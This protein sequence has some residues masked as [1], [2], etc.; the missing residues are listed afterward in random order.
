MKKQLWLS[1]GMWIVIVLCALLLT[2]CIKPTPTPTPAMT[3]TAT[4][5]LAPTLTPTVTTTLAPAVTP[6]ITHTP[7]EPLFTAT[8]TTELQPSATPTPPHTVTLHIGWLG[9][10]ESLNPFAEHPSKADAVFALIYDRLI[11]HALDN[12]YAP[13]FAQSW[14]SPDGGKTWVF[15]LQP[16]VKSHD[17]QPFTAEDVAFTL[18][19]YQEHPKFG[20]YGGYT[21]TMQNIEATGPNSLTITMT[22][23]V[24]NIE[25]FV[26]WIPLLPKHIWETIE[27]SGTTEIDAGMLVGS[28]P[29]ILKEHRPG[30]QITLAANKGYWMGVPRVHAVTFQ[31]YPNADALASA[32]KNGDVDLITTVPVRLIADLK[33]DPR[34]QVVSGPQIRLRSLFFNVSSRAQS[35]GHPA[36]KDPQ[37]R[38]AIARAIDKQQI[39]DLLLLGQGMPGLSIIPPALRRWFDFEIEDVA[40]DLQKAQL[41]LETAGYRDTNG[42]GWREMPGSGRALDFRLFVSLDSATGSHEAEMLGNWLRQIGVKVTS[43]TLDPGALKAACCPAFDY[44]MMLWGQDGGPDPGFLLST[45]TTAQIETGFN[46]S[47]YSNPAYDALYQQQATT[48]DQKQRRQTVWEMQ[49]M[50]FNDR[51]CVVLYYDLAVQAFR[52]DRFQNWLFVPNGILSL[53][54]ERS[55]LQVEP[56]PK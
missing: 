48:I 30:E 38:L 1:K 7:T 24:G 13:A 50:A 2:S 3:P 4:P 18:H 5:V 35:T 6:T 44:D 21:V 16:N 49:E 9:A 29:F 20:L 10:P 40:F 36:L 39:I 42:D 45:L 51:P 12:T 34:I 28:G 41:I 14:A 56:V 53:T 23:P 31:T 17:G 27:I 11:Y 52:K 43:Q 15:N 22:E 25:A 33:S 8:P 54:D 37:V 26:H 19:L 46:A 47:G 55:L 32:L